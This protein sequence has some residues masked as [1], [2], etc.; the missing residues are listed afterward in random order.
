MRR[1]VLL[2]AC[3]LVGAYIG[4][5]TGVEIGEAIIR[6][7]RGTGADRDIPLR[8]RDNLQLVCQFLGVALGGAAGFG[9]YEL[10][11]R[12]GKPATPSGSG[13]TS[14]SR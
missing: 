14:G 1:L 4:R 6:G 8:Q 3:V 5:A 12:R 2:I 10:V 9:V 11:T 7:R 13:G